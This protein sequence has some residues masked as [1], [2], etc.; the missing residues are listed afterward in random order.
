VSRALFVLSLL[1]GWL[2]LWGDLS[3]ANVL[4]GMVLIAGLLL[5]FP[6]GRPDVGSLPIR[7]IAVARFV[8]AVVVDLLHS[9]LVLARTVLG[10]RVHTVSGVIAVPMGDSS[11]AMLAFVAGL[12]ALSPGT[13][14][15]A[16]A[17]RPA[18]IY[19]HVL[20]LRDTERSRREIQALAAR[21]I[22]AFGRP[23]APPPG[24]SLEEVS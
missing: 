9:N 14:A 7:P 23:A 12:L 5:V 22:A 16:V 20:H 6:T 1:A 4:S 21:A 11:P 18:T 3:L 8:V 10:P 19:V 15:V 2:L 17:E 13:M 24:G